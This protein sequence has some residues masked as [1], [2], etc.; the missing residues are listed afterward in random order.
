MGDRDKEANVSEKEV[1]IVSAVRTAVGSFGGSL[2]PVSAPKLGG[3]VIKEALQ[4]AGASADLVK[5]I[6]MGCVLSAGQGQAPAR[7]AALNAGIPDTVPCTTVNKVCGSGLQSVVLESRAIL[8]GELDVAVAGGMENMSQCPY[9]LP[10]ARD[11]YRLGHGEI[12]DAMVKDGLWDVYNDLH[13]GTCA[14]TVA[15]EQDITR[16]AQDDFAV[17]SYTR[18][19]YATDTGA[20]KAEIVPVEIPQRKGDPLVF[21]EDE[22]PKVFNETK[23]RKMP[24]AFNRK[25]G[26]ITA[27]NA[28]SINDGAGAV[29]LASGEAVKAHNL[30]PLARV[31]SWGMGAM[32]PLHFTMAPTIAI[33]NAL[34]SASMKTTDIDY[35][36]I[37]EAFATV[38][39]L[40][41]RELGL[42][43]DKVNPLGGAISIGHPIG[44]SGARILVTLLNVLKRNSAKRG[45]ASLCIGG[46]E[47]IALIVEAP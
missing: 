25:D 20:N 27:G 21:A 32:D 36:E 38:P 13:M 9:I 6:S 12:Q 43:H 28:S 47:G 34:E 46:G 26:T 33:R 5:D 8:L 2:A 4:R 19:A 31:V 40:A 16:E 18:A 17:A 3:V 24:P 15:N 42:D 30:T 41:M 44:G 14:D 10:K 29:V 22:G 7:Q 45:L 1:Y 37:N 23:M 35:W 39:I 11:G